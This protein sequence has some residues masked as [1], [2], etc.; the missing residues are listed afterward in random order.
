MLSPTPAVLS[1]SPTVLC[2]TC[3]GCRGDKVVGLEFYRNVWQWRTV[4][5]LDCV[6]SYESECLGVLVDETGADE[7]EYEVTRHSTQ[8]AA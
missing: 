5:R 6:E 2:L 3:E 4:S 7:G 8:H 1:P